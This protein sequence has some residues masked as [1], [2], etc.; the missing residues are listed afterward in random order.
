MCV[1]ALSLLRFDVTSLLLKHTGLSCI[2]F[3]CPPAQATQRYSHCSIP[4]GTRQLQACEEAP[5]D[6]RKQFYLM[7][8]DFEE[9][10]GLARHCF[11]VYE[12]AA[13]A[14]PKAERAAVYRLF[15]VK[16]KELMGIP[17]VH[18]CQFFTLVCMPG[19]V[20]SCGNQD[21]DILV[22]PLSMGVGEMMHCSEQ[23]AHWQHMRNAYSLLV[24][25]TSAVR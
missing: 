21:K 2:R 3:A 20:C 10:Y 11:G 9:K 13:R 19:L 6:K 16:A 4:N 5:P 23:V 7:W 14:V 8:A 18:F 22:S 12:K 24:V 1:R 17:K 15:V 25:T